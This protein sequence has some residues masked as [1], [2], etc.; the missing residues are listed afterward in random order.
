MPSILTEVGFLSNA[1]EAAQL[2]KPAYRQ[3]VAE[4]LYEGIS[5]YAETLS[6]FQM[7]TREDKKSGSEAR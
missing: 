5:K 4:A 6:H 1:Q 7:A 2:S 3:K